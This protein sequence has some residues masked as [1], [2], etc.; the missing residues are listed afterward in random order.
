MPDK[1][2]K[3]PLNEGQGRRITE[4]PNSEPIIKSDVPDFVYTPTP[5][6]PNN[7][8]TIDKKE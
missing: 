3:A 5:P 7:D 2:N 6:A 4:R 8:R 1:T